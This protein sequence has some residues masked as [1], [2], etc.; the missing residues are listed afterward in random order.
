M[1]YKVFMI[2]MAMC[3]A[4]PAVGFA[5]AAA[6]NT[7]ATNEDTSDTGENAANQE[8]SQTQDKGSKNPYTGVSVLTGEPI[9]PVLEKQRPI[10]VMYP[11]DEAAQP[12]YGL[13]N[14]DVFYEIMEEGNMSRQMGIIQNWQDLDRIGNIRSIRSYFVYEALEWDPIILH[15][16]GPIDYTIDILT[17]D[18]VDNI[19]GVGG[20]LGSDYGCF[21]SRQPLRAH[22][23][24][25]CGARERSDQTGRIFT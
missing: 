25:G 2:F 10:A 13:S 3:M 7:A 21:Y 14:V 1:K 6:V 8:T 20:P 16:G 18:D 9:D 12:Q 5:N 24:H 19:N 15:Y 17:R 23:I 4:F 11:I 22:G